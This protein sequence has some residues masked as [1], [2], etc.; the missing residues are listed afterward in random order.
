MHQDAEETVAGLDLRSTG[1]DQQ[2]LSSLQLKQNLLVRQT[3]IQI[4]GFKWRDQ[5]AWTDRS[6]LNIIV[7]G[8]FFDKSWH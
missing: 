3:L 4:E 5:Q 2:E 8:H 7:S 6:A 1:Q